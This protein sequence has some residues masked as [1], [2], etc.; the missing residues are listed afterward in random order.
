ML[1]RKGKRAKEDAS[2]A[3]ADA[4]DKEKQPYTDM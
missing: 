4:K 2:K 1:N 3:K